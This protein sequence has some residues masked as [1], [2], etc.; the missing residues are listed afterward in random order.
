M[1]TCES[2]RSYGFD[3]VRCER[4]HGHSGACYGTSDFGQQWWTADGLC[5]MAEIRGAG[6]ALANIG[7]AVA[8]GVAVRQWWGEHAPWCGLAMEEGCEACDCGLR[9]DLGEL[10][11]R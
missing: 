3:T 6:I 1:R 8:L 10:E 2:F 7:C 4:D 5:L 9:E 11:F